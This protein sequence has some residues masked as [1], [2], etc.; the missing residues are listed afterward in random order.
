MMTPTIAPT[1]GLRPYQQECLDALVGYEMRG[2]KRSLVAL[3]TGTGKTVI[4]SRLPELMARGKKTLVLAHR[5][6][7]LEQSLERVRGANPVLR[8]AIEQ[9]E[10]HAPITSDV[11]I[12]S[13]Q[14]LVRRLAATR[15]AP[16]D[17]GLIVLDEAH[18]ATA[19][20]Y[21]RILHHFG[22]LPSFEGLGAQGIKAVAR[23]FV[24]PASAPFLCGFTATPSR[25]DGVGLE[26]VFDDIVFQ[27]SIREMMEQRYLCPLRALRIESASDLTGVKSRGG[28]FDL[29]ELS[30][31]ID[32]EERN[33]LVLSAYLRHCAERQTLIFAATVQHGRG[34]A[35]V[36]RGAGIASAT[37]FG[38]TPSE[39]RRSIVS[40]FRAGT[41]PVLINVGVATEG[42]DVPGVAA[43]IMARPTRSQSLYT[44]MLGRGLRPKPDE[45]DLLVLDLVDNAALGVASVNS[46][47]GFPPRMKLADS[48]VLSVMQDFS[49]RG[50]EP[51]LSP[52]ATEIEQVGVISTV[53]D[54]LAPIPSGLRGQLKLAWLLTG[55]GYYLDLPDLKIGITEDALGRAT[56]RLREG[57]GAARELVEGGCTLLDGLLAAERFVQEHHSGAWGLVLKTA[58]WRDDEPT[59]KQMGLLRSLG[60]TLPAGSSKGE[61]STMI[62]ALLNKRGS[63]SR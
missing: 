42:F 52:D 60:A 48:T 26:W 3:P 15:F 37:L 20:T 62:S 4:F 45:G 50:V 6:E 46:L 44:Q 40:S 21:R 31:R 63:A 13:V 55:N 35:G 1:I 49:A 28:D 56:V 39:E 32:T 10:R 25:A 2:G 47:F 11:T 54:L 53:L 18:H 30:V 43:I 8:I 14:T 58:K 22:L 17:F 5:E 33:S 38:S 23:E 41:L 61:A 24:V 59:E 16:E 27:R 12:A 51:S 57:T 34:L 29:E 36:F 9:G 19:S 7:L